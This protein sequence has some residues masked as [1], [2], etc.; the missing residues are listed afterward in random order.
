MLEHAMSNLRSKDSP[1]SAVSLATP[2][3]RRSFIEAMTMTLA[4]G[5]LPQLGNAADTPANSVAGNA[6]GNFFPGFERLQLKTTGATINGVRAGSGPPLL[7]LHGWPQSLLE[8]RHVAPL[9][10][11]HYTVIATDLRGYGDSSKPADGD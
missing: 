10:A 1:A 4:T 2:I 9:L 6:S 8:W 7:L 5:A 11:Q 3:E